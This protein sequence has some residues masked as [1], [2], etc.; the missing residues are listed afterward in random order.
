MLSQESTM[1]NVVLLRFIRMCLSSTHEII[2]PPSCHFKL[3]HKITQRICSG[4]VELSCNFTIQIYCIYLG[5]EPG[6]LS[7]VNVNDTTTADTFTHL[8]EGLLLFVVQNLSKNRCMASLYKHT[9]SAFIHTRRVT[10]N[11]IQIFK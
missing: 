8:F 9:H 5:F 10:V 1:V 3:K 6:A 2:Y 4:A 7:F 11:N